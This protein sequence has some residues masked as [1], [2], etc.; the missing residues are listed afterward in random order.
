MNRIK[1]KLPAR[2]IAYL[3]A[4]AL[5]GN[6]NQELFEAA[7]QFRDA[8]YSQAETIEKLVPRAISDGLDR[9]SSTKTVGSAFKGIQRDPINGNAP[10]LDSSSVKYRKIEIA[11]SP[12]PK[13]IDQ[14][15]IV[16]L[17]TV[18]R[19]GEF[20]AISE[21]IERRDDKGV[22]ISPTAGE[23]RTRE[24]WIAD[25]RQRG[26]EGIFKSTNGLFVR[27]NPLRDA[28]GKADKDV[29]AYRHVLI[30]AD[31]GTKEQQLAAIRAI[32]LPMPAIT[33]SGDRSIHGIA[34]VDA[35]DEATYRE[36]FE[37]LREY[38]T[39]AFGLKVD[40][41]NKNPSRFSRMPGAKRAR[42]DHDTN[43]LI[44][45]NGQPILDRQT[46]LER[47]RPGKP[48]D[49]WVWTLP[50]DDGEEDR[51]KRLREKYKDLKSKHLS[52]ASE[53]LPL[54]LIQGILY[55]TRRMLIC[56]ASKSR[57]SWLCQQLAFCQSK[58]L[59]LFGRFQCEEVPILYANLE[60]LEASV[61]RRW[62]RMAKAL[63][64]EG[65]FQNNIK[66]ISASEYLDKIEDDFAE[67]LSIQATDDK[68]SVVLIDP[69]WRLLGNRDENSN[70]GIGQVL[71]PFARF[72]RE[73]KA[74][75]IGVHHFAKGSAA[76]KEAIDRASGAGAWMRDA[77]TL[78]VFTKHRVPD[79]FVVDILT[80]DFPPIEKFV[81][82]FSDPLIAIDPDLDPEDLK[83]PANPKTQARKSDQYIE[84]IVAVL[85]A[86]DADGGLNQA[87]I[88]GF[89][90]I[91]KTSLNRALA[92]LVK[93][94]KAYKTPI[95]NSEKYALTPAFREKLDKEAENEE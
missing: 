86:T 6:R 26:L 35:P 79:A 11:P 54:V 2:T 41:K 57:K 64:Y 61:K 13:P 85:Y 89:T 69:M 88:E 49:E 4:G 37:I 66:I 32:G 10:I 21:P 94:R 25:I 36:R 93:E 90:K 14:S 48:W 16:F 19:P 1:G 38:C 30:E 50:V 78:L 47:E 46:L 81:V 55:K 68:V 9:T 70:T 7:G 74:S 15:A 17:E 92:Q 65:D 40:A 77:A 62:R 44:L 91:P 59:P 84:K 95:S 28:A 72:S 67:W 20:V 42:R 3:D 56:G 5:K 58:G 34:V 8:G 51:K 76:L 18:F 63:K 31:E 22:S 24:T 52:E 12:L 27:I 45:E 60:L 82:R 87:N 83:M 43:E 53:V 29:S 73:A 80:N 33:C 39:Q 71:K 75:A 23:V